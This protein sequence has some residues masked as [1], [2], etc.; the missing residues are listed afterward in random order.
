MR[1]MKMEKTKNKI[2]KLG[3]IEMKNLMDWKGGKECKL[4]GV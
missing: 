3:K 1:K 4:K 2:I